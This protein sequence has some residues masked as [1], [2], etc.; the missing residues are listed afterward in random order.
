M[1]RAEPTSLFQR[2]S[3]ASSS[4]HSSVVPSLGSVP[5]AVPPAASAPYRKAFVAASFGSAIG[6][7]QSGGAVSAAPGSSTNGRK[8]LHQEGA[9]DV[10]DKDSKHDS[11]QLCSISA[12]QHLSRPSEGNS[13]GGASAVSEEGLRKDAA[14]TAVAVGAA[15]PV[16]VATACMQGGDGD[17]D[18]AGGM[19]RLR[20]PSQQPSQRRLLKMVTTSLESSEFAH[21]N[22][23][24]QEADRHRAV[25]AADDAVTAS[26][27]DTP[28]AAVPPGLIASR[29]SSH[30]VAFMA[31][32]ALEDAPAKPGPVQAQI[33]APFIRRPCTSQ[34]H[35]DA[36]RLHGFLGRAAAGAHAADAS[37]AAECRA[38]PWHVRCTHAQ[39]GILVRGLFDVCSEEDVYGTGWETPP[40]DAGNSG[41]VLADHLDLALVSL[42]SAATHRRGQNTAFGGDSSLGGGGSYMGT[43][44]WLGD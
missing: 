41:V 12:F 28:A 23:A 5:P 21:L 35:Q 22:L 19:P 29:S 38:A 24:V 30:G 31:T 33:P 43:L 4:S 17:E 26:K 8:R 44:T 14:V 15:V 11:K 32:A 18:C 2:A 16:A 40:L 7:H 3:Y 34:R 1:S 37:A 20:R 9:A 27:A 36:G 39:H 42:G 25:A 6:G 13:A 10:E